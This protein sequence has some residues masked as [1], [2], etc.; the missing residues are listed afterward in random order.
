MV[1][2]A[3]SGC[4]GRDQPPGYASHPWYHWATVSEPA[5]CK[6]T[7]VKL[8]VWRESSG[9]VGKSQEKLGNRDSH[10]NIYLEKWPHFTSLGNTL[11]FKASWRGTSILERWAG[12]TLQ[13]QVVLHFGFVWISGWRCEWPHPPNRRTN[14][15]LY[16]PLK[17]YQKHNVIKFNRCSFG[18]WWAVLRQNVYQQEKRKKEGKK[19]LF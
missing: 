16:C 9:K 8:S 7:M 19:N 3:Q 4:T 10:L 13:Q 5:G 12:L 2:H 14:S 11:N 15:T 6:N 17:N 18:L 1:V